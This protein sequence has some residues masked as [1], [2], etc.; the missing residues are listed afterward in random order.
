MNDCDPACVSGTFR[1]RTGRMV[2]TEP[3]V[4]VKLNAYAFMSGKVVFDKPFKGRTINDIYP[5]CPF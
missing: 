3:R 1:R 2:L 4:C 5:G